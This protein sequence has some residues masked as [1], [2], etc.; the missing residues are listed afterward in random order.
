MAG[1]FEILDDGR[2]AVVAGD[3]YLG[4]PCLL[5]DDESWQRLLDSAEN[6]QTTAVGSVDGFAVVAFHTEHGDGIV[7]TQEG[8]LYVESGLIGL[9]PLGLVKQPGEGTVRVSIEEGETCQK[10]GSNLYFGQIRCAT[11]PDED[12]EDMDEENA[13]PLP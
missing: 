12:E 1:E 9:V 6:F 11:S 8:E 7:D 3:Y 5:M 13:S 10:I 2:V 4:D